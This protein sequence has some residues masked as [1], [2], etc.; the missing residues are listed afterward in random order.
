[1]RDPVS[2]TLRDLDWPLTTD[3]LQL[4]PGLSEDAAQ[5]WPWYRLPEVQQWTTTLS[6]DEAEH[7]QRWEA[8]LAHAMV[9]LQGERI[10]AVGKVERQ[11]A[12][13]QTDVAEQARGQQAE[14]GWVL[15][16]PS[17]GRDWVPSS[18]WPSCVSHSRAWRCAG[19]RPPASPTTMPPEGS[20][21]RS[22]CAAKACSVRSPCTAA[23]AGWMVWHGRYWPRSTAPGMRVRP[24]PR[25]QPAARRPDD[26]HRDLH[27]R[28]ASGAEPDRRLG[29]LRLHQDLERRPR[30]NQ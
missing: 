9:A 25:P 29:P 17:R 28:D 15:D 18:P 6:A 21:R 22:A 16:P 10:I 26:Q 13:S 4:R 7:R 23:G 8:G 27:H 11:D 2:L 30:R 24:V 19:S 5:I 14:L 12:W 1:Y 3:R 20:W